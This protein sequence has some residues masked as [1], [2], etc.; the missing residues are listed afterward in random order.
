MGCKA[1]NWGVSILYQLQGAEVSGGNTR[2]ASLDI[3]EKVMAKVYDN[4]S[5]R[6]S[7]IRPELQLFV[8][9][10]EVKLCRHD[11][12]KGDSWR[13]C[14]RSFLESKLTEEFFE[15]KGAGEKGIQDRKELVDLANVALFLWYR[16]MEEKSDKCS[17]FNEAGPSR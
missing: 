3:E 12:K 5:D 6:M 7:S 16:D 1:C 13:T 14:E 11:E 8:Q 2:Q 9:A 4:L 10:M 15:W 17:F